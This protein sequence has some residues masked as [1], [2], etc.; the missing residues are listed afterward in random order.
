MGSNVDDFDIQDMETNLRLLM[1]GPPGLVAMRRHID[2]AVE[3]GAAVLVADFRHQEH[4]MLPS[5]VRCVDLWPG[6]A[7]GIGQATLHKKSERSVYVGT[8]RLRAIANAFQPHVI[9][10][11]RLDRLTYIA[12]KA[13]LSPLVVS[14][15]GFMKHWLTAE[16]TPDD[17]LWLR[18]LRAGAH[19]LLVENPNLLDALAKVP[20]APLQV[21]CFPL[22]VDSNLFHP[23]NSD[24]AMA[25]RFA[26]D[27]PSDATV[28]LS[29]RGWS[30][31]YGQQYIMRAFADAYY[32]LGRPLV[33]VLMGL[34]RTKQPER[35]AREVL[36]LGV[37]L[38]VSHAI[39]WIPEVPYE[40]MPGVYA[41]ADIVVNYPWYDTFPSTLLEAAACARPVITSDLPAYRNTF[42]E[43][44]CRLVE[45]ENP[46]AL[47]DALIGTVAG[48]P[49][50]WANSVEQ[51]RQAVQA[52]YEENAQKQR[53]IALYHRIA[54]E[55]SRRDV[56]AVSKSVF[57]TRRPSITLS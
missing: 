22:G 3:N 38:G 37:S 31:T 28:V 34:G 6:R 51:A 49:I 15:W 48:G 17:R 43:R 39:R 30:Q 11:Y 8:L 21:D 46:T 56:R 33:L 55:R 2:W 50:S 5:S 1:V 16:V 54:A 29:P 52:E 23:G 9:H 12:L 4:L 18:R 14:V 13:R 10:A 57:Q 32:R 24:K 7:H 44:F 25:W 19:T 20:L 42:I 41:L 36:D 26:L 40:D 27:I 47:A 53:L 45:P 35:L